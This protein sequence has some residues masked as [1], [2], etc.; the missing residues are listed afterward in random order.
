MTD[1]PAESP[2]AARRY[3][4]SRGWTGRAFDIVL[5]IAARN[6]RAAP[7]A[8]PALSARARKRVLRAVETIDAV[9]PYLR[10]GLSGPAQVVLP[11]RMQL[12]WVARQMRGEDAAVRASRKSLADKRTRFAVAMMRETAAMARIA[13]EPSH[14]TLGP[15]ELLAA[16]I[17]FGAEQPS[18]SETR[19]IAMAERWKKRHARAQKIAQRLAKLAAPVKRDT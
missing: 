5:T 3:L 1:H 2:E 10:V 9:L 7:A 16:A 8:P 17:V 13:D 6:A 15:T 19:C 18:R 12:G 4:A 14:A 11:N